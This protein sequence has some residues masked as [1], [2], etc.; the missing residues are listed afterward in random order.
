MQIGDRSSFIPPEKPLAPREETP[1]NQ[2]AVD[3]FTH[4]VPSDTP[5]AMKQ[6]EGKSGAGNWF[7]KILDIRVPTTTPSITDERREEILK[8][9]EPGDVILETN[10]AYPGWQRFEKLTMNSDYTH[11]AMY[12]GDGKFIEATTGDPSGKGVVENDLREYLEGRIL[13]EII[14]P[15]YKTPEDREAAVTYCRSQLG[16]PYDSDFSLKDD[17]S[18]YCAELVQ[19]A[20]QSVPN[21]IDTPLINVFGKQAVAPDSFEGIKD[22]KVVYTDHSNFWKNMASHYPV[23]LGAAATAAATGAVL[24]P[25]GAMGGFVGGLLLSILVGNKMQTGQFGLGW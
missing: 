24:G 18:I 20:L 7:T 22:A 2:E 5:L 10:N 11:A 12:V 19:R 3:S 17:K 23:A 16:K 1:R 6:Q 4:Q 21:K 8:L 15:P 14:R 13:V 25:L 9:I